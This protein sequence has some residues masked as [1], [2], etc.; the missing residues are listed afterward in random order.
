MGCVWGTAAKGAP[1]RANVHA[2][3]RSR[4]EG[5]ARNGNPLLAPA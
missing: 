5:S 3:V 4:T 1:L 2:L